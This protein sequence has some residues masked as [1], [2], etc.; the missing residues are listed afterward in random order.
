MNLNKRVYVLDSD[1]SRRA[2]LTRTCLNAQ[3]HAEPC[4]DLSELINAQRQDGII[5]YSQGD[6]PDELD[7][8]FRITSTINRRLPVI[9]Y[10]DDPSPQQ[11]VAA[12]ISGALSYLVWPIG[13]DELR[14]AL[15]LK[16]EQRFLVELRNK[17]RESSMLVAALTN[18]EQEVLRQMTLG[19]SSKGMARELGISYR[20]VEVH[21]ASL[22]KKLGT[23]ST[24]DA[25]RIGV[26]AGLD[27]ESIISNSH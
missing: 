11:I 9:C 16:S 20:T 25:V 8:L 2:I 3:I 21:R 6:E 15:T 7:N 17:K 5:L 22:L 26:Y 4:E 14:S 19:H 24:S 23:K 27:D 13:E 12:M 18:R 1:D 10:S